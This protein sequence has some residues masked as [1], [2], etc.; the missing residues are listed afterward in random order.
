[1]AGLIPT[2]TEFQRLV[3]EQQQASPEDDGWDRVRES[4]PVW[5]EACGMVDTSLNFAVFMGEWQLQCPSC[6][7]TGMLLWPWDS[8]QRPGPRFPAVP[9]LGKIY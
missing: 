9:E 7:S 8:F 3:E 2:A 6:G 5:C 4:T 1:M